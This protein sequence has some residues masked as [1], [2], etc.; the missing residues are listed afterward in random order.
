MSFPR[1]PRSQKPRARAAREAGR[2]WCSPRPPRPRTGTGSENV[3]LEVEIGGDV[4]DELAKTTIPTG[5]LVAYLDEDG[6][7]EDVTLRGY[8]TAGRTAVGVASLIT[9]D[10]GI[11]R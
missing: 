7:G 5:K 9:C 1:A 10:C 11:S 4:T 2:C 6:A 8:T 3:R